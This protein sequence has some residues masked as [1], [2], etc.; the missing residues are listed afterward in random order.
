MTVIAI[1]TLE[2]EGTLGTSPGPKAP[3]LI[4]PPQYFDVFIGVYLFF[5]SKMDTKL[6]ESKFKDGSGCALIVDGR[7]S[8]GISPS[9]DLCL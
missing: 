1:S 9:V 6:C 8:L 7:H 4:P 5:A 2:P 3:V